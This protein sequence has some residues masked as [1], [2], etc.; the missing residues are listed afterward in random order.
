MTDFIPLKPYRAFPSLPAVGGDLTS[1]S[2]VL[3]EIRESVEQHERRRGDP[4]D[5]FVRIRELIDAQ[6]LQQLGDRVVKFDDTVFGGSVETEFVQDTIGNILADSSSIN[7]TYDDGTPSIS[8]VVI[9][10][11]VDHDL[12]A[13]YVANEHVDHTAVTLTAGAGLTGG[14][15]ISANRTFDVGAGTGI[16]VNANDVALSAATLASLAL[17]DSAVQPG[18][19]I[20]DADLTANV[21]LLDRDPQ[22]FTGVNYFTL[23]STQYAALPPGLTEPYSTR[24]M[25]GGVTIR[26][27]GSPRWDFVRINT[28]LATPSLVTNGN[29]I[30]TFRGLGYDG[31]SIA[32]G[33]QIAVAVDTTWTTINHG[34]K[35]EFYVTPPASTTTARYFSMRA[36]AS[37]GS[38]QSETDGAVGAPV[39][40]FTS[41][42][43][44][45]IYRVG[46]DALGIATGGADRALFSAAEIDLTATLIDINGAV[47][48]S[49]SLTV[50]ANTTINAF[51]LIIQSTSGAIIRMRDTD[52]ATSLKRWRVRALDGTWL[53]AGEDDAGTQ[54]EQA[55]GITKAADGTIA[56]V[57]FTGDEVDL[58]TALV[59]INGVVDLDS[60]SGVV[61]LDVGGGYVNVTGSSSLGTIAVLLNNAL[62]RL[63]L[64]ETDAAANNQ[65]WYV[66]ANAERF[67]ISAVS[68]DRL[69]NVAAF[70]I[71]RTG[72]TID[73]VRIDATE[74]EVNGVLDFNGAADFSTTVAVNGVL[75]VGDGDL[76]DGDTLLLFNSDR[77]WRFMQRSDGATASLVLRPDVD[78]KQF[79]IRTLDELTDILLIQATNAG[80]SVQ[81]SAPNTTILRFGVTSADADEKLWRVA[82]ASS[83]G[84]ATFSIQTR[85]D[86]DTVGT[87]ALRIDRGTGT[88]VDEIEFNA[89]TFDMN[90]VLTVSGNVLA[91]DGTVGLLGAAQSAFP[92]SS[93]NPSIYRATTGH[94]VISA[95][96]ATG[97]L[98]LHPRSDN[99]NGWVAFVAGQNAVSEA[100]VAGIGLTQHTFS[101]TTE[102]EINTTTVDI[103]AAVDISGILTVGGTITGATTFTSA[104]VFTAAAALT[105]ENGTPHFRLE[106]TDAAANNQNWGVLASGE[107]FSMRTWNDAYSGNASFFVVER[108]GTVVDEVELNA[109]LLDFN[110]NMDVSGAVLF[111]GLVA[112]AALAAGDNDDVNLGITAV[113]RARISGNAVTS[114]LTGVTGGVDGAI[115]ILTN[116]SANTIMIINEDTG[117]TAANRFAINGDMVLPQNC[118]AVFIY[119]G[120]ITRWTRLN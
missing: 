14:G 47:D 101:P 23:T 77:A 44:T 5:S 67:N 17:A 34:T 55:L 69:T 89:T 71:D 16:T 112:P 61:A 79:I 116:V 97:A 56:L 51:E 110:G 9:P 11:G 85:T 108:T 93:S 8:A 28:S 117:S 111:T 68:D 103:N 60:A 18:D 81:L 92:T 94:S 72:T 57:Q 84:L 22:T 37:G 119:D 63:G 83:G 120:S 6:V 39:Y 65:L 80:S 104:A 107:Q 100:V 87:T 32:L 53:V 54:I 88:A 62:P 7:F 73:L 38:I 20:P 26:E 13:N 45:G 76:A 98:V 102:F 24:S 4:L 64:L 50:G 86:V 27:A 52:A 12:L 48:I 42:T 2:V 1:H 46:A 78:S 59:D 115:L 99:A 15:D 36:T 96:A 66:Y 118:S 90:G 95:L 109:T 19:E 113:T 105:L 91:G 74:F 49:S 43:D 40:T 21:A 33:G 29:I 25:V 58:T 82:A 106:E 3:R 70:F 30:G 75:T 10:G 114:N 31:S 35:L 41:D